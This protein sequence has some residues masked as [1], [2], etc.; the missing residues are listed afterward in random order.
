T[1]PARLIA[2][3]LA[4]P[5]ILLP[6]WIAFL[7]DPVMR[8]QPNAIVTVNVID[9]SFVIPACLVT[10]YLVWRRQ[11]WGFAFAGVLLVKLFTMGLSLIIATFWAYFATNTPID[12]FQTPIYAAFMIA[13]GYAALRYLSSI[14]EEVPVKQSRTAFKTAKSA[15]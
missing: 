9:L 6:P 14:Q 3:V 8:T 10:A 4:I 12:T 11:T 1:M 13:G 5:A 15:R 2:I 7:T